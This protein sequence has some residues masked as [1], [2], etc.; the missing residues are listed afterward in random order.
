VKLVVFAL[1]SALVHGPVSPLLPTAYEAT[2]LYYARLYPVWLLA[3]LGTIAASAGE[4]VTYRLVDWAAA[5]PALAGLKERRAVRWSV[6]AFVRAPFWATAA[7]IFSPLP[8][9]AARLLAPLAGYPLGKFVLATA[10]GRFPRLLII[11][12]VGAIV[13]VP[14]WLLLAVGGAL[15]AGAFARRLAR[16]RQAA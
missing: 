3:V 7:I 16:R 9:S 15:L 11:A 8:D 2:L 6:A 4:I 10:V 1:I 13:T 12:G 5:R 14:P